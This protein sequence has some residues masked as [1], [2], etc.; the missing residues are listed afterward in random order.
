M[1]PLLV[2]DGSD[3]HHEENIIDLKSKNND[4]MSR[5]NLAQIQENKNKSKSIKDSKIQ[6]NSKVNHKFT[7]VNFGKVGNLLPII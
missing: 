7:K 5:E 1:A 6:M 2:R 3:V 4:I